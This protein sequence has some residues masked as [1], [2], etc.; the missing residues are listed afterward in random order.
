MLKKEGFSFGFTSVRRPRP[1]KLSWRQW[2][3]NTSDFTQVSIFFHWIPFWTHLFI[4]FSISDFYWMNLTFSTILLFLYYFI[5]ESKLCASNCNLADRNTCVNTFDSSLPFVSSFFLKLFYLF[6]FY[7]YF[8]FNTPNIR[9][10]RNSKTFI[11][12]K[13]VHSGCIEAANRSAFA[14]K[15]T[16]RTKFREQDVHA[17]H[18]I[19]A[20]PGGPAYTFNNS[21]HSSDRRQRNSKHVICVRSFLHCYTHTNTQLWKYEVGARDQWYKAFLFIQE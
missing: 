8:I 5:T 7:F 2:S 12:K 18:A 20:D 13:P 11:Q 9:S 19:S 3:R 14:K 10:S 17:R 16:S 21:L 15:I 4:P 6:P 1:R